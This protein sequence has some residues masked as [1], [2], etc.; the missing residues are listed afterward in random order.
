MWRPC[1]TPAAATYPDP[2]RAAH[3]AVL[4][5]ADGITAHLREDRRHIRDHDMERLKRQLFVPLNFE[6]AADRRDDR[7]RA[8]ASGRMPP[9]SCRRSARSAPP[10]AASTSSAAAR[11]SRRPS[12]RT[13]GGRHPRLAVRRA[14]RRGH[15]GGARPGRAGG[16][17]PHRHL[18]RGRRRTATRRRIAHELE[19]LRGAA[20]ARRARSASRSMPG[21]A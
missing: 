7:D 2:I 16:R 15:G 14:G 3:L 4:A 10:R 18:L 20:R 17:T 1:A 12:R 11:H 13:E 6:M 21:T 8:R 5:G 9:A 19:R